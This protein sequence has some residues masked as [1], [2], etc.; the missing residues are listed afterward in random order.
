MCFSKNNS[1]LPK[2]MKAEE[3]AAK[4]IAQLLKERNCD[5]FKVTKH[6]DYSGT[7]CPHRTLDMGWQ[8][9]LNMVSSELNNEPNN[10]SNEIVVI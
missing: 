4:L 7:Y 5:I 2:F 9:F 10:N 6:Q 1:D 8:R 3:N